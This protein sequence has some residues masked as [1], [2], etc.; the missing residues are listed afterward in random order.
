MSFL[1]SLV[2]D[3]TLEK[4]HKKEKFYEIMKKDGF[5]F[6]DIEETSKLPNF[7]IKVIHRELAPLAAFNAELMKLNREK[8][9][10]I[11][12]AIVY[13]ITDYLEPEIALNCLDESNFCTIRT[14][15]YER[16]RIGTQNKSQENV[17]LLDFLDVDDE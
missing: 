17:S 12:D 4:K 7:L 9:V 15:L 10:N 11:S 5:D 6:D 2:D 16:Y 3:T 1:D 13:L 8:I 14:Q